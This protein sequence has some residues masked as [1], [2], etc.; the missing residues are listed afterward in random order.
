[1]QGKY[2]IYL[3]SRSIYKYIDKMIRINYILF[4]ELF[5]V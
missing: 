1:M 4:K 2:K 3:V 5:L